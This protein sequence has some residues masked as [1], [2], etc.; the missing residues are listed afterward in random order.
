MLISTLSLADI[1]MKSMLEKTKDA[2]PDINVTDV[3]EKTKDAV[4]D[5]NLTEIMDKAKDA[6]DDINVTNMIDK[7]KEA[8]DIEFNWQENL[9]KA[10]DKANDTDKRVMVMVEG[11]N[12]RWCKKMLHRT[13]GDESVQ[14][15]LVEKYVSVK[16]DREDTEA[17]KNLPEI[18]GVPT[19]FF[20]DEDNNIV[21]EVIGYF[22]VED[23]LSY[24]GDVE[25]KIK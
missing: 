5:I 2:A 10:Y 6:V 12:C 22:N 19:I 8:V 15:K 13:I 4:R 1:D 24:I 18:K 14:K 25:K 3:I 21:E 16:V 23:F 11:E 20:M 7:A 9:K 17:M